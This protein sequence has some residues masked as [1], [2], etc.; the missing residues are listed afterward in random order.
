V[1][2]T[3]TTTL[4]NCSTPRRPTGATMPNDIAIRIDAMNLKN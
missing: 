3:S 1:S 2:L 4:S